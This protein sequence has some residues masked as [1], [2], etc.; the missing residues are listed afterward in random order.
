M[1]DTPPEEIVTVGV[2]RASPESGIDCSA[3]LVERAAS[4][5]QSDYHPAFRLADDAALGHAATLEATE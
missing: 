3:D 1:G 2:L 4:A 5:M